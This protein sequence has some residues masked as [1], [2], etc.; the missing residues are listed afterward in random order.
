MPT[1][2]IPAYNEENRLPNNLK[3]L[4]K[5]NG[6]EVIV[7]DDGSTDNTFNIIK[8]TG[9]RVIRNNINKGKGESIKKGLQLASSGCVIISDA[10]MP[11]PPEEMLKLFYYC[12]GHDLVI[13]SRYSKDA[14][15]Q[16]NKLRNLLGK[17][18]NLYVKI[19]LSMPY[20]DTQC[21]VKVINLDRAGDLIHE[22][23][24]TGYL[25]DLELLLLA[26][27]KNL[28]VKEVGVTWEEKKGS[29]INLLKDPFKMLVGVW[30]LRKKYL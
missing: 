10:D 6:F 20:Q 24:E 28:T 23:N 19:L 16:R 12:P 15:A 7:V 9:A 29:K 11:V 22:I 26:Q 13:A 18:F 17:L 21:G 3:K 5:I 27:K 14:N 30:A 1:V 8:E 2:I 25:F 4:N